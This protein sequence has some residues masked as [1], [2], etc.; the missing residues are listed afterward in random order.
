MPETMTNVIKF[1]SNKYVLR[2][3][4]CKVNIFYV[5]LNSRDYRDIKGFE[6][7]NCGDYTKRE[8]LDKLKIGGDNH[9]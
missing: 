9:A 4:K 6:C 2:C 1:P 7:A 5:V 3:C 8:H